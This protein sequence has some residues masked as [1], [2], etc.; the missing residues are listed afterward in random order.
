MRTVAVESG[1]EI[2]RCTG[3]YEEEERERKRERG[4]GRVSIEG[5][6]FYGPFLNH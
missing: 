6:Q 4:R 1:N 5:S 3:N 2:L